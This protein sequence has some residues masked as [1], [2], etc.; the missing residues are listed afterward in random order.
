M[1]RP[2]LHRYV[3]IKIEVCGRG[4]SPAVRVVDRLFGTPVSVENRE[5]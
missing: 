1:R 2:D 5:Y 3:D 4:C